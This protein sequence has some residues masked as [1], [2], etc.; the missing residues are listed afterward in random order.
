MAWRAHPGASPRPGV[1]HVGTV[2][3]LPLSLV[4]ARAE[5]TENSSFPTPACQDCSDPA[6]ARARPP[7]TRGPEQAGVPGLRGR[8]PGVM[9]DDGSSSSNPMAN[10]PG[11][12]KRGRG[13]ESREKRGSP[14]EKAE[15][16]DAVH[17]WPQGGRAPRGRRTREAPTGDLTVKTFKRWHSWSHLK[18]KSS[19]QTPAQ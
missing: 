13:S 16:S 6:S 9:S 5:D 1:R 14:E 7:R 12:P 17:D 2:A 3:N 10:G 15:V 8:G 19:M 18:N 4:S 11:F